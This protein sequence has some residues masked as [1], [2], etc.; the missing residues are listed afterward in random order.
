MTGNIPVMNFSRLFSNT[1]RPQYIQ[2]AVMELNI[3]V[4]HGHV[5][6]RR[7]I[8][9]PLR[10]TSQGTDVGYCV[11]YLSVE[12][13]FPLSKETKWSAMETDVGSHLSYLYVT[14]RALLQIKALL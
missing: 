4:W 14:F 8:P 2:C 1:G 11:G 9:T 13:S 10:R 12:K 5:C 3:A 7:P 6:P